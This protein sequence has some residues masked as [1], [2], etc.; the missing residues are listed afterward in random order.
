MW[1]KQCVLVNY[2]LP[3]SSKF[4]LFSCFVKMGLG[5]LNIFPWQLL[6][7]SLEGTGNTL[8][9]EKF[10]LPG[11]GVLAEQASRGR[12]AFSSTRLLQWAVARSSQ[13]PAVFPGTSLRGFYSK[14]PP[15][16]HLPVKSFPGTPEGQFPAHFRGWHHS[17]FS[18]IQWSPAVSSMA[19][20]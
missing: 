20:S 14:G 19:R 18:A 5:P 10:L 8:Q 12:T 4:H 16:R 9:E 7:L 17:N 13:Q 1:L 15:V 3:Y 2:L 6:S 11:S